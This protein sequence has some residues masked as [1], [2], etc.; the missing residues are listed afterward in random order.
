MST[1]ATADLGFFS[2][3]L[4]AMNEDIA[5]EEPDQQQDQPEGQKE[6]SIGSNAVF[7]SQKVPPPPP[8]VPVERQEVFAPTLKEIEADSITKLA[9]KYWSNN[10]RDTVQSSE[11]KVEPSPE[12]SSKKRKKG[13]KTEDAKPAEEAEAPAGI[14]ASVVESI[15]TD[16]LLKSNFSLRKVMLLEFSQYLE[17]YLWPNYDSETSSINHTLSI[18]VMLNEKFRERIAGAWDTMTENRTKFG[19]FFTEVLQILV[20]PSLE[21]DVV[22]TECMRLVNISI[23]SCLVTDE[24]R[25]LE[26]GQ[27]PQLRKIWNKTERKLAGLDEAAQEKAA[28]ERTFLST[29]M[30][31]YLTILETVPESGPPPPFAIAYCER[32]LEFML[33]LISQLPTR[34]Y[35]NT[36]LKDHLLVELS[37]ESK[38]AVR[39]RS[40]AKSQQDSVPVFAADWGSRGSE[41]GV[42]FYQLLGQLQFYQRFEIDEYA[43]SALSQLEYSNLHYERMQKLQKLCFLKYRES[44]EEFALSNVGSVD[45]PEAIKFHFGKVDEQTLMALCHDIGVRTVSVSNAGKGKA[46][47]SLSKDFIINVLVNNYSE[48]K[49][50]IEDINSLPLFPTE[51]EIFDETKAPYSQPFTNTHCLS[52]PKLN[53]QFLTMHD[54]LLRNF[55]LFRLE[56]TFEIRQDVEDAVKR[57]SPRFNPDAEPNT[58]PTSFSGW[59]RMAVGLDKFEI[60]DIGPPNI[61]ENRPSFVKADISFR[62]GKFTEVIRSEWEALKKHDILFLISIEMEPTLSGHW[63]NNGKSAEEVAASKS[64]KKQYGIKYIRACEILEV[65]GRDGRAVDDEDVESGKFAATRRNLRVAMDTNQ[66]QRDID[67]ALSKEGEDVHSTFN[68]VMRR[69]PQENNF[70][71]VLE[72]IRDLMQ[73]DVVVPSWLHDIFLGYGDPASAQFQNMEKPKIKMDFRDTFLDWDHLVESFPEQ[74]VIPLSSG[75]QKKIDAPYVLTFPP[76]EYAELKDDSDAS[77]ALVT[78]SVKRKQGEDFAKSIALS[79]SKS[80]I[81][82]ETYTLPNMGPYPEDQVRTNSV[83]F[84]PTQVKAIRAGMSPGLTMIVGPPGTGKTDVAVQIIA[85]LYHNHPEEHT[86]LITHSNQALNQLFEKITELDIDPRH[87]LRLGHG[88]DDLDTDASWGKYGRVNSFLEMRLNLLQHVDKLATSLG[89]PGAH[90]STCETAGYFFTYHVQSRWDRYISEIGSSSEAK[91]VIDKF[92]FTTF[93]DDAP[94]PL[95]P[96][97]AT[98]DAVREIVEGCYRH[99]TKIFA[100]LEDIRAFELLRT[101]FDRNNYLLVK[102]AKIIALTCTHAAIKRREL[103]SLGFRYDNVVMEES[104]QILEVETFIPLLLQSADPDTGVSRLKRVVMIGDHYQLPPVVKNVAFQRYGNMEQSLFA[105]FVRLGVPA[106]HL[107]RQ[108]RSRSQIADL[109]RW[110][111][112]SLGDLPSVSVPDTAF[113]KANPGFAFDYQVIDVEDYK[114]KGETEPM[115][116]F[117]QNLGEAEYIVATYQYMRLQGYPASKISILTT[118]NGQKALIDDVLERRCRWNPLFGLPQHVSTVDKFQ[119]QQNDYVL[120]SLVR[121]RTVGH[122]RDPRRLIVA[123]SRARLG[124]YVFCRRRLFENCYELQPAFEKLLQRPTRLWLRGGEFYGPGFSRA[125]DETGVK[126]DSAAKEKKSGKKQ[127]EGWVAEDADSTFEMDDVVHMGAYVHQM[128]QEQVEWLK[129][130]KRQKLLEQGGQD[131]EMKSAEKQDDKADAE[132]DEENAM[133]EDGQEDGGEE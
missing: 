85:N 115:P 15:W 36:L 71:A 14:D 112:S 52:I 93:F 65:L 45:T 133:E 113:V 61:G 3:A 102:E 10:S 23:W 32:F 6:A 46:V 72:S 78:Q 66:Y 73:A 117:L 9:E 87:L 86:L 62:I 110:R 114:G 30:K 42:L 121:T 2:S 8:P 17:K 98:V 123:L 90:G 96:V 1:N 92:P 47:E 108:G 118:Y 54:Y 81:I 120:L 109:F 75:N 35:F 57:L 20:D 94:Q 27:A 119:G 126:R 89:V 13:D 97:D 24:K 67:R 83:R 80:S 5:S 84:T 60:T 127:K 37:L 105:R 29:L 11:K 41:S 63:H 22:R 59:A 21:H 88:M 68:I 7:V 128:I 33:D 130:Q 76:Q 74:D 58:N 82:A 101:G 131:V 107:D 100:E 64:F 25:E 122:L 70:K 43:G 125:V 16:E 111:Y 132:D 55:N 104:A 18:I 48:R 44:L 49:S 103:V 38:L 19:A 95:F 26:F 12:R 56:S 40:K 79:K 39:G 4:E 99:I 28:F 34:R 53:L 77:V 50:H 106:I 69:K 31:R 91:V 124:L 129:E 51:A 116:H